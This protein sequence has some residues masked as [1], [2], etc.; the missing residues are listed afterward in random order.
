MNKTSTFFILIIV[1]FLSFQGCATLPG[2]AGTT[3]AVEMVNTASADF[4]QRMT[5]FLTNWPLLSGV[6]EG[7][8]AYRTGDITL[9]MREA[10][11]ALDDVWKR[12]K[13]G[14]W[15]K[16]D[17]GLAFGYSCNLFNLAFR[18][19]IAKTLPKLMALIPLP[20]V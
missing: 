10:R 12:G 13:D 5:T 14:V 3:T 16:R 7:Y 19:W 15:E 20:G 9:S 17:L 1:A 6:L 11:T 2:V 18:D 4:E 8:F